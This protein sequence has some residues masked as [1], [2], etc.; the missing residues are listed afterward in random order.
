MAD[1]PNAARVIP[2][3]LRVGISDDPIVINDVDTALQSIQHPGKP[4]RYPALL[5]LIGR[6]PD[7]EKDNGA[8]SKHHVKENDIEAHGGGAANE[9]TDG[10]IR[11]RMGLQ[12]VYYRIM[13]TLR[14]TDEQIIAFLPEEDGPS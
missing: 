6:K 10:D 3:L 9:R 11:E 12:K 1:I 13:Q 5:P 2:V 7:E 14:L 4:R 8:K